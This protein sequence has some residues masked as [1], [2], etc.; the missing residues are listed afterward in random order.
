MGNGFVEAMR[1]LLRVESV[2]VRI[3]G[4]RRG[5]HGVHLEHR[6]LLAVHAHVHAEVEEV[7][8]DVC[9]QLGRHD[10][11]VLRGLSFGDAGGIDDAGQL[12]LHLYRAVLVE[13]PEE[14]ILVITNG[15]D[16]GYDQP[17]GA[18]HLGLPDAPVR[19]LP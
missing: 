17:P 14:A 11:A 9:V 8:V 3:V 6:V 19:V 4:T 5:G 13:I 2:A 18:T 10:C 12:D 15:G 1:G 16:A 7:L